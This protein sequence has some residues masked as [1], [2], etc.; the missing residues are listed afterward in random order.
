VEHLAT[1]PPRP[2]HDSKPQGAA[3]YDVLVH[4]LNVIATNLGRHMEIT[5]QELAGLRRDMKEE[6][7]ERR[8][9]GLAAKLW[10][11][12]LVALATIMGNLFLKFFL[13]G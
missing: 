2:K 3:A 10:T 1:P 7:D 12:T 5:N 9:E 8:R 4:N 6:R 11:G 13:V